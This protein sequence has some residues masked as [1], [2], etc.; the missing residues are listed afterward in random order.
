SRS[1]SQFFLILFPA[2]PRSL[3]QFFLILFPAFPSPYPTF[4]AVHLWLNNSGCPE[5]QNW[6]EGQ[7]E[8]LQCQARGRAEPQVRCSK[9]GN[10]LTAGIPYPA[11]RSHD[12]TYLC[13]VT[14]ALGTAE[15][16]VTVHVQGESGV[17]GGSGLL[18]FWGSQGYLGSR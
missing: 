15:R 10:S 6:T 1:L 16:N 3:S 17:L 7:Q 8:V 4:P 12:G 14:N 13:S 9:D 18:E 5:Q 11:S 2:F